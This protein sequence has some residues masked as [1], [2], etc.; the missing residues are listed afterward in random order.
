MLKIDEKQ[1]TTYCVPTWYRDENIR[2]AIAAVKDRVTPYEGTRDAPCAVVG[3]GPSLRDTWEQLQD[4]RYIFTASGSHKFLLERGITPSH[5]TEVDPRPH[6][7]GLMGSPHPDVEYLIA[8]ACSPALFGHLHGYTVKLWHIF[9][10]AEESIR[11][12]PQGDWSVTGG[13]DCGLRAITLARFLGFTDIH[14]FGMDAS[15]PEQGYRHAHDHPH[16]KMALDEVE[17]EGR[18]FLTTSGMLA[19]AQGIWHEL[20][21]L[22]DVTPH[23]YGD[24][25]IQHM[26]KFWTRPESKQKHPAIAF[27]KPELISPEY[28]EL[29][30]KLFASNVA[31][32]VGG[33][34]H[35]PVVMKLVEALKPSCDPFPT[36]TDYGAGRC[37]LAKALPFPIQNYDPCVPGLDES[38]KP[39]DIVVCTDCAEH[40]EPDRL[41]LILADIHRCTRKILYMVIHTGESSKFLADGRNAHILIRPR[42]WWSQKLSR[43]FVIGSIKEVGPLL[44]IVA[45]PKATKNKEK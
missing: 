3:S 40:W 11:T 24:G 38:P 20:N 29:N 21:Q 6:K 17:Y 7:V 19:A 18:T 22:I 32:G 10:N 41:D 45:S 39:T 12:L 34:K 26:A 15:S 31:Y 4:F 28:R 33:G 25:L 43:F 5:H 8:S 9:D 27:R 13:I 37:Y 36:V 42:S 30:R 1:H 23:F 44:H 2:L 35:A 16:T 14:L